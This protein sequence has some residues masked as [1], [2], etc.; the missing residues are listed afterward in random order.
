MQE[1]LPVVQVTARANVPIVSVD[2]AMRRVR[3][4]VGH[5]PARVGKVHV[6]L[7]LATNPAHERPAD[8]EIE[9]EATHAPIHVHEAAATLTEAIDE[10]AAKLRRQLTARHDRRL[11]RRRPKRRPGGPG[12]RTQDSLTP[13][14]T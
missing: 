7:A 12:T 4:V 9:V 3:H 6:V 8:I 10:A 1:E 11:T 5:G 2:Y 13:G 14:T